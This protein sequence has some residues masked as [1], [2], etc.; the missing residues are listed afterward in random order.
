MIHVI[1]EPPV[2]LSREDYEKFYREWGEATKL[3][4]S[5]PSF[6]TYVRRRLSEREKRAELERA[7]KEATK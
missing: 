1:E 4:L 2:H 5:P 3:T 7:I 6:E